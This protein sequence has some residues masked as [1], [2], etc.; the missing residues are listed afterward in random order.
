MHVHACII[1]LSYMLYVQLYSIR[2]RKMCLVYITLYCFNYL[3]YN[4]DNIIN[5]EA[6][7]LTITIECIAAKVHIRPIYF[8][9]SNS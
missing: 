5:N 4:W 2:V 6:Q 8:S 9:L 3:L 1:V 7:I